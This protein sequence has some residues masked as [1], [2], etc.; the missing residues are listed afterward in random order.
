MNEGIM[1][2]YKGLFPSILMTNNPVI[3]F[4]CYEIMRNKILQGTNQELTSKMIVII[5]LISKLIT[6]FA[7][8]PMLTIKTLFQANETKT[9]KEIFEIIRN[10]LKNDGTFGLYKGKIQFVLFLKEFFRSYFK[11]F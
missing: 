10:I 3:Q 5:S 1:G 6:T 8:Y 11:S 9:D 2:F 4:T 7:T